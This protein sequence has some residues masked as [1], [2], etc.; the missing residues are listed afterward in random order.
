MSTKTSAVNTAAKPSLNSDKSGLLQRKCAC[1]N[2]PG[3]TGECAECQKEKLTLQRR[4][5]TQ[6]DVSEV[7]PIVHEVL[8]SPGQPLDPETSTFMESSFGH[9]FSQVRVHTDGKAGN[10]AHQ[11]HAQAFTQGQD[12]FFGN[13]YYQPH[14]K[15]G[16]TLLAHELTHTIQQ[17]PQNS[18]T[19]FNS[20]LSGY[21]VSQ[22]GDPLEHEAEA[23]A[24]RVAMG[25]PVSANAIST[26]VSEGIIARQ[27]IELPTPNPWTDVAEPTD[28]VEAVTQGVVK[29]LQADP[30]DSSGRVRR[31]LNG[32]DSSTREVVLAR[33]QTRL[34][35]SLWEEF[36]AILAE[37][38]P[39]GE[40]NVPPPPQVETEEPYKGA[41][42]DSM[43][44]EGGEAVSKEASELVSAEAEATETQTAAAETP[45]AEVVDAGLLAEPTGAT[46]GEAQ[47][48]SISVALATPQ[49]RASAVSSPTEAAPPLL[50]TPLV[51]QGSLSMATA[52]VEA[53][54]PALSQAR[55][56]AKFRASQLMERLAIKREQLR[57]QGTIALSQV[58]QRIE[59]EKT[60]VLTETTQ[61]RTTISD[62]YTAAREQATALFAA[63][64]TEVTSL[65]AQY[66]EQVSAIEA[67]E[68][69]RL[70]NASTTTIERLR[71]AS[72]RHD[73]EATAIG[74][75]E[76]SRALN[77]SENLA[78]KATALGR[79]RATA[80]TG[81]QTL[82]EIKGEA[83][84]TVASETAAHIRSVGSE[85][86]DAARSTAAEALGSFRGQAEEL[87]TQVEQTTT[88]AQAQLPNISQAMLN[89]LDAMLNAIT[90]ELENAYQ[91]ILTTLNDAERLAIETVNQSQISVFAQLDQARTDSTATIESQL[92]LNDAQLV[93][94]AESVRGL[95][96]TETAP[97]IGAV[98]ALATEAE[99]ALGDRVTALA[100]A[101]QE[102]LQ[103]LD[104]AITTTG[105]VFSQGFSEAY[106]S[107]D[108]QIQQLLSS[109]EANLTTTRSSVSEQLAQEFTVYQQTITEAVNSTLGTLDE[110]AT[111]IEQSVEQA[112][113][114]L[115]NQ[116]T[117]SVDEALDHNQLEYNVLGRPSK[118]TE[119]ERRAQEEYNKSFWEKVWDAFINAL[120][121][122]LLV[123]VLPL[124]IIGLIFGAKVAAI[125]GLIV[126]AGAIVWTVYQRLHQLWV[127]G[128]P[129]YQWV[130]YI[131]ASVLFPILPIADALGIVSL[132][133]GAVGYDLVTWR[134]LSEDEA[135]QRLGAGLA[136]VV[137]LLVSL[138][139][140]KAVGARGGG[141]GVTPRGSEP[142]VPAERPP[143]P[144][145]GRGVEPIN[146]PPRG[147]FVAGTKVLTL[148]GEKNIEALSVGDKV[149][150]LEPS[151]ATKIS[152]RI[153]RTFIRHVPVVLHIQIGEITITCSPEHP[154]WI[155]SSGWQKASMLEPGTPLLTITGQVIFVDSIKNQQGVFTVFNIE[156]DG[157][158]TYHVS[159][160]G[161]LVHNKA[162]RAGLVIE[163]TNTSLSAK[164]PGTNALLGLAEL[165]AAGYVEL[166]IYTA[167][168]KTSFRGGEVFTTL[169]NEFAA[170]GVTVRGVRGLWYG[171]DNLATFNSLIRAGMSPENAALQTFTGKMA[172]RRGFTRVRIDY[173]RSP[174]KPDGTFEKA[175]L[176]FE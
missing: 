30:E 147:C 8:R 170:R 138:G 168:A 76:A 77:G 72:N 115:Q 142:P 159:S 36:N 167:E 25:S 146:E 52:I 67:T 62:R 111:G 176:W 48:L 114:D 50:E 51:E 43:L 130:I 151:S 101:L 69:E 81:D 175:E 144:E 28:E 157:L 5:T 80:A 4:A 6:D 156:V 95:I 125:I 23:I 171:G 143:I 102:G 139:I 107:I 7:P 84:T 113:Q 90:P 71:E 94:Y 93:R 35:A 119:A 134:Q 110:L 64:R 96:E 16:Q 56:F 55:D 155:P 83:V 74:E 152:H 106:T 158:H 40:E 63:T 18:I 45:Q 82:R 15:T 22:P 66:R 3:L 17:I 79:S 2:S 44:Q 163:G 118:L 154:F 92:T 166:G 126:L 58:A 91:S 104:A 132:I 47:A 133:E 137:L 136:G 57:E 1:G 150:S 75:Q 32:L 120:L 169:L 88:Q 14:T 37:P 49:E 116:I 121:I 24:N 89:R 105:N 11:L 161:I 39:A 153:E 41:V 128:A 131:G 112:L 61:A 122:G 173:A 174:R 46:T 164:D 98:E 108:G 9:D 140:A 65:I 127:E 20:D 26:G 135:A 145:P 53:D 85:T 73:Q 54:S 19:T 103:Q 33:V 87:F 13:G 42:S 70:Q 27:L 148:E 12:I 124:V 34:P 123:F 68:Q 172:G 117:T 31:R 21:G 99:L 29:N 60:R 160:L 129:W 97:N 38:I 78:T 109:L 162:M 141:R 10:A 86:A 59:V 149:W 100:A 165:D